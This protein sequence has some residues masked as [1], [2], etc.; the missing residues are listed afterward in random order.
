MSLIGVISSDTALNEIITDAFAESPSGRWILQFPKGREQILEFLNF[1]LPEIVIVNFSD[2]L[3]DLAPILED[4]RKDSWLHNFGIIGLFDGDSEREELLLESLKKLFNRDHI[5]MGIKSFERALQIDPDFLPARFNLGLA[6]R[7]SRGTD[8][9]RRAAQEFVRI[10]RVDPDYNEVMKL[11]VLTYRD[12]E[13]DPDHP[14]RRVLGDP[15]PAWSSVTPQCG[16]SSLV[17][18]EVS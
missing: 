5:S 9:Y 16:V 10:V 18:R 13:V 7:Q 8:N 2:R 12:G 14:L 3:I 1:D 6:Y 15:L 17:T 4:V 11:L